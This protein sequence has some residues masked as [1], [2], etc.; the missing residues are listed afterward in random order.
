MTN[1]LKRDRSPTVSAHRI[2]IPAEQN[3]TGIPF[4]IPQLGKVIVTPTGHI[5]NFEELVTMLSD[6]W[7]TCFASRDV[8]SLLLVRSKRKCRVNANHGSHSSV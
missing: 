4:E 1:S 7:T 6:G 3:L 2:Q 8:G 5:R